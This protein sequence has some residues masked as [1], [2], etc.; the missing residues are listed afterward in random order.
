MLP[1]GFLVLLIAT[2]SRLTRVWAQL[3]FSVQSAGKD[4]EGR[5]AR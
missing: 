4:T 5:D 1:L 3:F 2:L